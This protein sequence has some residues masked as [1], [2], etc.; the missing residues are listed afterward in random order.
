MATSTTTV[1]DLYDVAGCRVDWNYLTTSKL[2]WYQCASHLFAVCADRKSCKCDRL[3][4][5]LPLNSIGKVVPRRNADQ[6]AVIFGRSGSLINNLQ[7]KPRTEGQQGYQLYSQPNKPLSPTIIPKDVED[8]LALDSAYQS[9]SDISANS[10][11]NSVL[12]YASPTTQDSHPDLPAVSSLP[13]ILP[14]ANLRGDGKDYFECCDANEDT[15][16]GKKCMWSPPRTP[17]AEHEPQRPLRRVEAFT[18]QS[19]RVRNE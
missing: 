17:I 16:K 14:E 11:P 2:Q 12:S 9:A 13:S 4:Q 3:Q 5:D 6:G 7:R 19:K 1:K 10:T 8:T 15:L 18:M